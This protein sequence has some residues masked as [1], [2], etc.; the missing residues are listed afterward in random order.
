MYECR[1]DLPLAVIRVLLSADTQ[2]TV[3]MPRSR[4]DE[5]QRWFRTKVV[6]LLDAPRQQRPAATAA[7]PVVVDDVYETLSQR[8][9]SHLSVLS[10]R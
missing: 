3:V 1:N 4:K 2:G 6:P 8:I 5:D 7:L 9:A 10:G